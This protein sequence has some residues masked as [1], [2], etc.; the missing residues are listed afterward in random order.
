MTSYTLE[1]HTGLIN[2]LTSLTRLQSL[3][4]AYNDIDSDGINILI[5]TVPLLVS[6]ISIDLANTSQYISIQLLSQNIL[7][8]VSDYIIVTL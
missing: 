4:L 6:L 7:S 3:S 5:S 1:R 8:L 2:G